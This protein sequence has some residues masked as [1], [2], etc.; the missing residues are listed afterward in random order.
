MLY[1]IVLYALL[2]DPSFAT[3]EA[4]ERQL[5]HVVSFRPWQYGERL[6]I[7]AKGCASPEVMA[8]VGRPLRI[9]D[10]WRADSY[11]PTGVPVWPI[12]D[13]YPRRI[14]GCDFRDREAMYPWL[15]KANPT[16]GRYGPDTVGPYW[17]QWRRATE[18]MARDMIR[19]GVPAE[20]V[21]GLMRRMW[22]VEK[23]HYHDCRG[24]LS[25]TQR[26]EIESWSGRPWAGGYPQPEGE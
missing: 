4:A 10:T 12:V 24:C 22:A 18:M 2:N 23:R 15:Y 26:T 5:V 19:R 8:R 9:Y 21:D 7:L 25:D 20:E 14:L 6:T 11:R 16:P 3:R 17:L 1:L 13:A